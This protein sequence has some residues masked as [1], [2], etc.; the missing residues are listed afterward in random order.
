MAKRQFLYV[1][2][3]KA[4]QTFRFKA[5]KIKK[6]GGCCNFDPNHEMAPDSIRFAINVHVL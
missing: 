3:S 6:G 5:L 4:S 2:T 1:R